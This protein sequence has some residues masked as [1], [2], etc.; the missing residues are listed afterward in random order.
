MKILGSTGSDELARVVVAQTDSGER[1]EFVESL[2]P[3]KPREEKW[4]NVISTLFG[5]PIRCRICDAGL[6]YRGKL[7]TGQ[8]L[9][10]LE[11]LVRNRWGGMAVPSR[12]WKI[13]FSRMGEPAFNL[14]VL[15]LL[16]ELPRRFDAPGLHPSLSTVAPRVGERFWEELLE[17]KRELY[18]E[19][20]QFQFS[21]HSTDRAVRREL[22]P[23]DTMDEAWMASYGER[24]LASGGRKVTLN[25]A[26]ADEVPIEPQQ[27]RRCFDPELFVLKVTPINPTFRL[28]EGTLTPTEVGGERWRRMIE[29]LRGA[30]YDLLESVGELDENAIGSNCGQ[31]LEAFERSGCHSLD[32][33]YTHRLAPKGEVS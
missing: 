14:A 8:M 27:L 6:R 11:H 30:G 21:L 24:M 25:F 16:R 1:I 22:I 31:Y 20:F 19:A 18:P 23:A 3:P 15:D 12:M 26:L 9:F 17:V 4:V 29:S 2:Q 28:R 32:D 33:A 13:Q 10:Q 7:T 5:C